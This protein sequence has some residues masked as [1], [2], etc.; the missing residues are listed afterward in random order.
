VVGH[1]AHLLIC[2]SRI[3]RAVLS[4]FFARCQHEVARDG[5]LA[6]IDF[7]QHVI[8]HAGRIMFGPRMIEARSMR[9]GAG[10]D[11]LHLDHLIGRYDR[12]RRR[13]HV[14]MEIGVGDV[15][16]IA[17]GRDVGGCREQPQAGV[18]DDV[19]AADA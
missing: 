15:D 4:H 7:D 17:I 18:L 8:H 2:A 3:R 10:R 9:H 14:P 13:N 5:E 12:D 16:E 1:S 19:V 11:A 6:G